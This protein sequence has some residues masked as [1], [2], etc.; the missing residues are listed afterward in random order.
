MINENIRVR[1]AP[2]PT[3]YI[4]I[5]NTRT[6]LFNWLFARKNNGTFILR[7]ED[8]DIERSEDKYTKALVEDL[9]WLGLDWD[10]GFDK[11]GE[12]GPYKQ[13]E[14]INIYNR[15]IEEL[16]QKSLVYECYCT[17]EELEEKR[18]EQM[19]K[20]KMPKYDNLCRNLTQEQIQKYKDEG[21]KPV[22]RFKVPEEEVV[23]ED[24]IRGNVKFNSFVIGDFIVV[25]SDGM[26]SFN[27]AVVVDDGLMKISHIIRGED[28][29][30]N[31]PRHIML[32]KA[33]GF[34]VPKFAHLPMI[35]GPSGSKLSKREGSLNT[36][37]QQYRELGYLPEAFNNYLAFLGWSP[38]SKQEIFNMKELSD[39]FS[40]KAVNKSASIFD[41]K[42]LNWI[43]G[44]HIQKKDIK[45]LTDLAL[46]FLEKVGFVKQDMQE[47]EY[48]YIKKI[49][50]TVKGN[51]N[52][53]SEI[54]VEAEMFFLE[55]LNYEEPEIKDAL[56]TGAVVLTEFKVLLE[57]QDELT[58]EVIFDI[59]KQVQEKCN[60]KG[61]G[62]YKPVRSAISARI[63]GPE[64]YNII[65]LL[66]KEKTIKRIETALEFV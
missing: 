11:G 39:L 51:V 6:T 52:C 38:D 63:H 56:K 55:E 60:V 53:L 65:I 58:K 15:Y 61:P 47:Q 46:P 66:G 18:Q 36:Y 1:F 29:L 22:I 10:E 54:P 42:K 45:E 12:Y 30:S 17:K 34:P 62:L 9:R 20:G 44:K 23:V 25:K 24:I 59:L 3:G 14:R 7:I 31:T 4:H 64:L 28:H 33:L 35:L 32:F 16:K 41:I 5:G 43:S 26:T 27:F 50:E 48:E 13:S 21:R 49:V 40:L 2:S 8:T 37:I 19:K 57:K